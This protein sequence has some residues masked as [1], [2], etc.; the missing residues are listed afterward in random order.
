[1]LLISRHKDSVNI[2][3]NRVGLFVSPGIFVPPVKLSQVIVINKVIESPYKISITPIVVVVRQV[4]N[5]IKVTS[6]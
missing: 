4:S 2:T 1:M 5:K 3:P 6:N